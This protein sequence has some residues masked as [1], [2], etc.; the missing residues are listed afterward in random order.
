MSVKYTWFR[1]ICSCAISVASSST[2]QIVSSYHCVQ[3]SIRILQ[4]RDAVFF[5]LKVI[6][7]L[8]SA[9]NSQRRPCQIRVH[10]ANRIQEPSEPSNAQ[11]R[12]VESHS[13]S[14]SST[15]S[16]ITRTS[17]EFTCYFR[18]GA[19]HHSAQTAHLL[20]Q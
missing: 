4:A 2:L 13:P 1:D 7:A 16:F 17:L 11:P 3:L 18:V 19:V 5:D 6:T 9:W 8:H 12:T 15:L 14:L 10:L 20:I